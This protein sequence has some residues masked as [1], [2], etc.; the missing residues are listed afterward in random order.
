MKTKINMDLPITPTAQMRARHTSRGGF[1]RTYKSG[2]QVKNEDNLMYHLDDY[3]PDEPLQGPIFLFIVARMP[4][5]KSYS[6]KKRQAA[7]SNELKYTK[8]PD[9]DNLV[10]NLMDCMTTLGF[11]EDDKQ[12]Y[13]IH[14]LKMY[15]ENPGWSVE[16]KEW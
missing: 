10:K 6:K 11:W 14:A 16:L 7:I 5:P 2:K 8:K 15:S 9:I 4:I 1:S 12:V 13:N 3:V